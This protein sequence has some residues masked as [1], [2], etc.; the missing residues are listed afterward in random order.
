[1]EKQTNQ[2]SE[3]I[4]EKMKER[5]LNKRRLLRR[6]LLTALMA[7][8]FGTVA[9]LTFLLLEPIISNRL[10]PEEPPEIIEFNEEATE[11]IL[12]EDMFA[13]DSE[14]QSETQEPAVLEDEQI[15]RVLA[16]FKLDIDDYLSMNNALLEVAKEAQRSMV[17]VVG[18]S[19]DVDWFNNTY[20]S[21]STTS[22]VIID[23]KNKELLIL[24]NINS[25]AQAETIRVIFC[26]GS[27]HEAT[28][29]QQDKTTGLAV[30]SVS[31]EGIKI[32]TMEAI[33]IMQFG[34][35]EGSSLMGIPII[36]L[37]RPVSNADSIAYGMVTSVAG[38]V[39]LV[40]AR[41]KLLTTDI[42][43]SSGATGILINIRGRMIGLIDNNYNSSDTK[44]LISAIG[45]SDLRKLIEKMSNNN[46]I[47]Y[48]GIYSMDVT[49]QANEEAGVPFGAYIT[50]IDLDSPAMDAGIQSGDVIIK[51]NDVEIL[52]NKE[53]A[54]VLMDS[55]PEQILRITLMRQ[56]PEG[57]SAMTLNVTLRERE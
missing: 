25:I 44:N 43:G 18:V 6:T 9:C 54:D 33:K 47:A 50:E 27:Q 2:D 29:R 11:E 57:Y 26:D 38:Q 8:V 37:G 16:A 3:V 5:P 52:Q 23:D 46:D 19:S 7:V 12:P 56:S 32:T 36:A 45:I 40:D 4:R 41:Y 55:L 21:E 17:T 20:E 28:I 15:E 10:Y 53:L 51:V 49:Q 14:M 13:D 1:M 22:G 31:Q 48:F 39:N 30:L 42:Y 24:V 34:S 35:S